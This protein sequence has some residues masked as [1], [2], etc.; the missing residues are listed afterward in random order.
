MRFVKELVRNPENQSAA[1]I[2][3]GYKTSVPHVKASQ[4]VRKGSIREAL[5]EE[6]ERLDL[7]A[8]FSRNWLTM[9][10]SGLNPDSPGFDSRCSV[11][12]KAQEQIAKLAGLEPPKE[13]MT[14]T[15]TMAL[16][17]LLPIGETTRSI[18]EPETLKKHAIEIE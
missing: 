13:T 9:L 4:L 10:D 8:R 6:M 15:L 11:I 1:L 2:K 14:R 17:D 3:A 7:A 18:F 12:L 16:D 5:R